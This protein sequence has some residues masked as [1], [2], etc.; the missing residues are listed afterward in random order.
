MADIV[1]VTGAFGAL[2][3]AVLAELGALGRPVAAVDLAGA[4]A[5]LSA[6]ALYGGVDIA[7]P[8]AVAECFAQI[9][10]Q[11]GKIA[12]LVTVA[13]GFVWQPVDGGDI[14]AW[15]AMYRSNLRTAALACAQILP[16]L[17]APGAAI[18]TIAAA[19]TSRP[20][21]GMAAYAASK[22]GV[23]ALTES[24]AEELRPR[25]VR[26]NAVLPTII[27]TP[28]NRAAMPDADI[29][30]WVAPSEIAKVI[31]FLLSD[32]AACITGAAIR[33]R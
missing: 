22:A 11:H 21:T 29:A 10:R 1:V 6:E 31:A 12:G 32:R 7:E 18:V 24:L 14:G 27:D 8:Q 30:A 25:G 17:A 4:P 9:A 33:T 15:D 3:Q 5:G 28:A 20:G 13:G 26:V 2:G 16:Y 23:I 19:A